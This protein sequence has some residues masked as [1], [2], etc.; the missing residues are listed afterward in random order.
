[1]A[2]RAAPQARFTGERRFHTGMALAMATVTF[3][4]FA[5]TYY[6]SGLNPAARPLIPIVHLHGA[7]CTGWVL[8]LVLQ[9]SLIGMRRP[10]LHRSFGIAGVAIAFAILVSGPFVALFHQRRIHTPLT[11]GTMNDPQV[12]LVYPMA[13]LATFA[14][15]VIAG[16]VNR[17]RPQVHKRLMLLATISLVIP[18]LARI[19][20]RLIP[21]MPGVFG[22]MAMANLFLVAMIVH[23]LRQRGSLH[24]VTLWGGGLL[25]LSEP[26][27]VAIGFSAPWRAFAAAAM[28]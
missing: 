14:L 13:V 27:R 2:T 23:D 26:L 25:L 3:I 18:A 24:P 5:P 11:A 20:I 9:T 12:F 10:D 4:G 8:L 22:G 7:L 28:A 6:L 21:G 15:F 19:S 17:N 16:L 1:M